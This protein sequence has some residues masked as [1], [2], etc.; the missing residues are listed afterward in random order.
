MKSKKVLSLVVLA[1]SAGGLVACNN[2]SSNTTTTP[3]SGTTTPG[4]GTT[5]PVDPSL[6]EAYTTPDGEVLDLSG[7]SFSERIEI[8]GMMEEWAI[9]NHATGI[10]LYG[11]GGISLYSN[12]I[13]L[14]VD[15]YVM[16]YGFGVYRE[17]R[18]TQP[19]SATAEPTEAYRYYIHDYFATDP[20]NVNPMDAADTLASDLYGN[21]VP[22]LW[23]TRL[24]KDSSGNYTGNYEFY[25]SLA[26][27]NEDGSIGPKAVNLNAAT[28]TATKWRVKIR[29]TANTPNLKYKINSTK[30]IKGTALSSFNNSSVEAQDYIDAMRILSSQCNNYYYGFQFAQD[31]SEIVGMA[32][33]FNATKESMDS[34]EADAAWAKVGYK[35]VTEGEDTYLEFEFTHPCSQFMAMYRINSP[36]IAPVNKDFWDLIV[37]SGGTSTEA[38]TTNTQ[39]YGQYFELGGQTF[40]PSDTYLSCGP[41]TLMEYTAP[42]QGGSTGRVVFT[43]NSEWF[44]LETEPNIYQ[45]LGRVVNFNTAAG[46]DPTANYNAFRSGLVDSTSVPSS[47]RDQVSP[48]STEYQYKEVPGQTVWQLQINSA[49]QEEWNAIFGENGSL[50]GNSQYSYSGDEYECEPAMSNDSFINGI[51]VGIDREGLAQ[52]TSSPIADSFF[53]DAYEVDPVDHIVYNDTEAH[54]N[55]LKDYYPDTHGYNREAAGTLFHQAVEE[56]QAQGHYPSGSTITIDV[57]WQL[58][59]QIDEEGAQLETDLETVFNEACDDLGVTLDI[60][61]ISLADQNDFYPT[62]QTGQY[63]LAFASISGST[64]DPLSFFQVIQ[65]NNSSYFTLSWGYDSNEPSELIHWDAD[66]DGVDEYMSFDAIFQAVNYGD[67]VVKDGRLVTA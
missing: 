10:P 15:E 61:N 36:M 47:L 40:T 59:R 1:L 9:K 21:I 18:I 5:T 17:G 28:N 31:T 30:S 11:D 23:G 64:L 55:A 38:N 49:T 46:T 66:D 65:S 39:F 24:E 29:T 67:A 32:D 13:D 7:V 20:G 2:D 42:G 63:D 44:E 60:N 57:L 51:Y 53:S 52:L 33:Y 45:V 8:M 35:L 6:G 58:A 50:W 19:L 62:V 34:A 54:K 14:P 56:L 27:P 22:S 48:G 43:K 37:N 4:G 25:P 3:G 12:R 16:N 41:Y 26:F